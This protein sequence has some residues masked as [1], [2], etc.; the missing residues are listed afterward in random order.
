[1][2]YNR[3]ALSTLMERVIADIETQLPNTDARLPYSNLNVLA[4]VMAGAS[5]SMYGYLAYIHKQI[6]PDTADAEHLERHASIWGI[7][8]KAAS[9]ATGN[10]D[11]TGIDGAVIPESTQLQ[12]SD[13]VEFF[14]TAEGTIASGT[15]AVA[16]RCQEA[17]AIGNASTGAKFSLVSPLENV[18]TEA[19]ADASSLVGGEDTETDDSLRARIMERI[20]E[21]P[22]GGN[23]NDYKAWAKEIAGVTRAWVFPS[24]NGI[25]T[26]G[27]AFVMDDNEGSIIPSAQEVQTVQD[28][29]DEQRPVTAD[30]TVFAPT[31]VALDLSITLSPNT[32]T[33]Q[34][35]V[36]AELNDLLKR[37]AEP[38][39]TIKISHIREAISIAA[40]EDDHT[41]TSPTAD[42]TH[43]T[44]E[45][46]VLGTVTW[47]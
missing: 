33:V 25:G 40:G 27:V 28:H 24:Q 39:G 38:G 8:R 18:D 45:I 31:A 30:V 15:A 32:S 21:P 47:S 6:L 1:M 5:Y 17:G 46:A 3:P 20:Q 13:G 2:P 4:M 44:G 41:L 43:D 26:V 22:H 19:L 16:V 34:S 35:A 36:E 14:T 10:L 11:F 12:R 42:V 37:E 9:Y 7:T 29:V 23:A